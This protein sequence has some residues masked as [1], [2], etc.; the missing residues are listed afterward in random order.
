V[1]FNFAE[2]AGF[3]GERTAAGYVFNSQL[4]AM[5][6]IY[7]I[8]FESVDVVPEP[9]TYLLLATGLLPLGMLARRKRRLSV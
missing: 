4:T 8:D 7:R 6:E 5:T 3:N 9:S 2:L 1:A